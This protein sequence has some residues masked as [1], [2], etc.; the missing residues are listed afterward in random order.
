MFWCSGSPKS[1]T[2]GHEQESKQGCLC[3]STPTMAILEEH[4]R[5]HDLLLVFLW[6]VCL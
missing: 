5:F 4:I 2:Q 1:P 6:S 3:S